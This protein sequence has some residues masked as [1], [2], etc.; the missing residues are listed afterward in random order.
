MGF[1]II[2]KDIHCFN[3][4]CFVAVKIVITYY[5]LFD[6]QQVKTLSVE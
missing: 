5:I 6:N 3:F 4:K 2:Y 1:A